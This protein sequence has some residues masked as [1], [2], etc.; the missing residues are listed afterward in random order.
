MKALLMFSVLTGHALAAQ[1]LVARITPEALAR[2]QQADP[3]IRLKKP[4]ER[5]SKVGRPAGQSIL[6]E[7]I[8]L[9]DGSNWT[10]VPQGAVVHVPEKLKSRI[11]ATP[12]GGLLS[13]ADFLTR[14]RGWV[15]TCEVSIAQASAKESLPAERIE[16]WAKQDKVVVTVHQ[17]GPISFRSAPSSNSPQS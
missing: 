14:N 16:F 7:S 2:L 17:R 5:E 15:T 4:T 8:I 11:N 9:S 6:A 3:M 12:S 10:I 13:W 1:P